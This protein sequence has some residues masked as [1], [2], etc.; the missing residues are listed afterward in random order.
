[1]RWPAVLVLALA[2]T[3]QAR[4]QQPPGGIA[5][6]FVGP[7]CPA[8]WRPVDHAAGR[9]IV[10]TN[11]AADVGKFGGTPLESG[12]ARSHD[13]PYVA[14]INIKEKEISG[15]TKWWPFKRNFQGAKKGRHSV[16]GKVAANNGNVPYIQYPL[17]EPA[18]GTVQARRTR[19]TLPY[20]AVSFFSTEECPAPWT[21]YH[22]ADGRFI[23]PMTTD[24][25]VGKTA[26]TPLQGASIPPHH[27]AV[28][29]P[30]SIPGVTYALVAGCC[31]KN[32]GES[33]SYALS[34]TAS[35]AAVDVPVLRLLVCRLQRQRGMEVRVPDGFSIFVAARYCEKGLSD[36]PGSKG[37]YLVGL[38]EGGDWGLA[39]GG[40]LVPAGELPRHQHTVS[41]ELPA[42]SFGIVGVSGGQAKNYAK[43]G[44]YSF[45]GSTDDASIH[46]PY[47]ALR[48][49]TK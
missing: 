5:T 41:G 29:L 42:S 27:H 1:M 2:A 36:T 44:K 28:S 46:L 18:A 8:G 11:Q 24:V 10:G 33:G 23:V 48:Q 4:A 13:H 12:E 38:P 22:E 30:L 47:I 17:C 35:A 49:C 45:N 21:P 26:G 39:F 19:V 34:G 31:N 37:R 32:L 20:N 40:D 15:A 3:T 25:D 9:L 14:H 16:T 7:E 43:A 6:F